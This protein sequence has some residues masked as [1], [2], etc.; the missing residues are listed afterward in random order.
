MNS[1]SG[2]EKTVYMPA[3]KQQ[4]MTSRQINS[5]VLVYED[6]KKKWDKAQ[7]GKETTMTLIAIN[8]MVLHELN[9]AIDCA[10]GDLVQLVERYDRLSLVVGCSAQV[11]SVIKA[12]EDMKV[13]TIGKEKLEKAEESLGHMKRKLEL[14]NKVEDAKKGAQDRKEGVQS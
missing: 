14:L 11:R 13:R 4:P 9:Q 2:F 6:V 5:R 10:M 7:D 8:E 12:L 1:F 3:L